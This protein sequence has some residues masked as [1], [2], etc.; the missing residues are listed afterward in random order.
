MSDV[1]PDVANLGIRA[2]TV[3]RGE[4]NAS[5][6]AFDKSSPAAATPQVKDFAD[7]L[8]SEVDQGIVQVGST[9]LSLVNSLVVQFLNLAPISGLALASVTT[10]IKAGQTGTGTFDLSNRGSN[11]ISGLSLTA[12]DLKT[13][14]GSDDTIQLGDIT[15]TPA[16][17]AIPAHGTATVSFDVAVPA[18]QP[19]GKYYGSFVNDSTGQILGLMS[20]QVTS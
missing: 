7:R 20:I 12:S 15:F 10:P 8:K 17:I 14:T 1:S 9:L 5:L 2:A 4:M 18:T 11:P 13:L 6:K 16:T 19:T 3:L